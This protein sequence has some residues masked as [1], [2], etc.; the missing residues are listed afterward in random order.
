MVSS[1]LLV[2]GLGGLDL[3][4]NRASAAVGSTRVALIR[5][6]DRYGMP[7]AHDHRGRRRT[8]RV[9]MS[10]HLLCLTLPLLGVTLL[11]VLALDV[12]VVQNMPQLRCAFS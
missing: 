2:T 12:L 5:S 9:S 7:L 8:A 10:L 11:A 4:L 6:P 1:R 3:A